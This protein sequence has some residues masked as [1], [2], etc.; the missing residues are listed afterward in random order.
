MREESRLKFTGLLFFLLTIG[1][2]ARIFQFQVVSREP[3][4]SMAPRQY[5]DRVKLMAHRGIIYDRNLNILAM[6]A[7]VYSL[8]VDPSAL[9]DKEKTA[10]FLSKTL[11]I[12]KEQCLEKLKSNKDKSFV[13]IKKDISKE[14]E[15]KLKNSG[16]KGFVFVKERTRVRPF[17]DLALQTIGIVNKD[18]KGVGG[19]EQT[20]NSWLEGTDGWAIL[21]RDAHNRKFSSL[22]YPVEQSK[23]GHHVILTI[24]HAMQSVVE[25]ELKKGV[26]KYK[27]K[28]GTAVLMDPVN[29]DI[30][31]MA[32]VT[33]IYRSDEPEFDQWIRNRAVQDCFEPGSIFKIITA[34]A[35]LQSGLFNMN[36]LIHCENGEYVLTGHK[37]HDHNE[38]YAWLTLTQVLEKSSNIGIAKVGRKLG[39]KTLYKYVR[40]F[41]FGNRTGIELPGEEPGLLL[42]PYKLN[43]FTLAT[44]SFGQGIAVT[45]L[46]M[47]ASVC[48]VANGG[49]LLKPRIWTKILDSNSRVVKES[50]VKKI[51]R[52]ISQGSSLKMRSMLQSVV[53][54]GS[55][56]SATVKGIAIAGKTGTAQKSI[57]GVKGYVPGAY[58]SSFVGFWPA[59]TPQFVLV[60][61]LDE[62]KGVY[63]GSHTAAPLFS[64]IVANLQGLTA[65]RN[66][67]PGP[68]S[69]ERAGSI[70]D[71]VSLSPE[72]SEKTGNQRKSTGKK[73]GSIHYIPDLKGFSLREALETLM[74]YKIKV[75]ITGNGTVV[76][77][78]PLPGSKIKKG[79]V[80]RLI[81]SQNL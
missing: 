66:I 49:E 29:G 3:W 43:D 44:L 16:I 58:V 34:A 56:E 41:G 81:C 57:E 73:H 36:S 53:K 80:C 68:K 37:I 4:C 9:E 46:Q 31:A 45:A 67:I 19:I 60:V 50:P 74:D 8:A 62:P 77:Q 71:F 20:F 64:D 30:L 35:A 78:T 25:A 59:E 15:K 14:A 1:V 65:P 61:V 5:Q 18:R 55:G 54:N 12:D 70:M 40:D 63:W 11:N 17:G 2:L 79:M 32:S 10:D 27:A 75:K 28:S 13:Y 47:A 51:R 72:I 38:S 76:N 24:D 6:D 42:P 39:K 26:K 23:D 22:D 69:K 33:G 21:Q 52:V 7:P 48:A